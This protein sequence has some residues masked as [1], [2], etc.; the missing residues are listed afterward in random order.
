MS[1]A[2]TPVFPTEALR[3][4]RDRWAS[5]NGFRLRWLANGAA[6]AAAIN[7]ARRGDLQAVLAHA[8]TIGGVCNVRAFARAVLR[9]AAKL[10]GDVAGY[11]ITE[12]RPGERMVSIANLSWTW[13][14]HRQIVQIDWLPMWGVSPRRT[15]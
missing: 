4:G 8:A 14:K 9:A 5:N 13:H 6:Q 15:H 12:N 7:A 11:R 10:P 3:Y 2:Q 1:T